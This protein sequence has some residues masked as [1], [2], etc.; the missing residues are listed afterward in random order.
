LGNF[1]TGSDIGGNQPNVFAQGLLVVIS[2]VDLYS[3]QPLDLETLRTAAMETG[4]IITVEDHY[5]AGGI[6]EA[7]AALS[8]HPVKVNIL[9]ARIMP[10]SGTL[11]ELLK[12]EGISK[13]SIVEKVG[14]ILED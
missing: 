9:T 13:E 2:D 12:F 10:K 3:V 14:K 5:Q 4:N 11:E 8:D 1:P 7:V 6:G